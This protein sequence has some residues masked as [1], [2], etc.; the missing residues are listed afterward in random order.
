MGATVTTGKAAL[1]FQ[2]K[3]EV[4]YVLFEEAYEKNCYPHEPHWC[5]FAIGNY[6]QVM[7]KVFGRASAAEGGSLT[8]R[9]GS[10]TPEMYL[11][12]WNLA[13]HKPMLFNN[14]DISFRILERDI[15]H[16]GIES[17]KA[18]CV[19]NVLKETNRL[20][21]WEKLISED[22][23][24]T[25][26]L[27]DDIDLI[28]SLFGVNGVESPWRIINAYSYHGMECLGFIPAKCHGGKFPQTMTRLAKF[29]GG[30]STYFAEMQSDG[31]FANH[32]WEYRV[33][34]NYVQNQAYQCEMIERG[35]GIKNIKTFRE[36]LDSEPDC[37]ADF[38]AFIDK[39]TISPDLVRQF[40]YNVGI[41]FIDA[42]DVI[43]LPSVKFALENVSSILKVYFK[44]KNSKNA[45]SDLL[46]A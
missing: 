8:N 36:V 16:D 33:I 34:A 19:Y 6:Q 25:L 5:C 32:E 42:E 2:A 4:I 39:S 14:R 27:Y 13:F 43:Q 12:G 41:K 24:V 29:I 45:V 30:H 31:T 1:A 37:S 40:E 35:L 23:K 26:S 7:T 20:D 18:G 17:N 28:I 9:A 21:V 44:R 10:L 46:A 38:D 22:D 3:N 15:W 11:R